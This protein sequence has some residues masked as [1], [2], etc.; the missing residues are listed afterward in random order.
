V[1]ITNPVDGNGDGG[2]TAL[3]FTAQGAFPGTVPIA[4]LLLDHEAEIDAHANEGPRLFS[5]PFH[6]CTWNWSNS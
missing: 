4:R 6:G 1:N 5:W 3:W 2:N